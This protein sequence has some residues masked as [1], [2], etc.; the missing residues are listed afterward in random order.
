MNGPF[1]HAEAINQ[2]R[3]EVYKNGFFPVPVLGAYLGVK[4]AGKRPTMRNW[5]TVCA[6]AGPKKITDWTVA[7]NRDV[8][9]GLLCGKL[10]GLDVDVLDEQLV[11]TLVA[12]AEQMLGATPLRRTG[13]APKTLLCYSVIWPIK[14]LSTPELFFEDGTKAQ[15][16]ILGEGQQFVAFGIHG[17]THQPY[18]W[19]GGDPSNTTFDR[20]PTVDAADLQAYLTEAEE[21]LREAGATTRTERMQGRADAKQSDRER[22]GR[23]AAGFRHDEKPDRELI[24]EALDH[25][26]GDLHYDDWVKV[27]FALYDGLGDSGRDLWELWSSKSS[28]NDAPFT[29][30]KWPSFAQNRKVKIG[31]LF[32]FAKQNGWRRRPHHRMFEEAPAQAHAG[33]DHSEGNHKP[34]IK[35][36]PGQLPQVVDGAEQALIKASLGIYQRG[37]FVVRPTFT[38]IPISGGRKTIGTRIVPVKGAHVAEMM[39][40]AATFLEYSMRMEDWVPINCPERVAETYMAREGLWKVP[41]LAGVINCPTLRPD[42]S[43]LDRPGYDELTGLL[44]QP[45]DGDEF[46]PVLDQPSKEQA[47]EA[48]KF[49]LDL[50]ETFPFVTEA[51][52]SVAISAVLT[53]VIRRSLLTAPCHGFSAPTAGSGKSKLIDICSEICDGRG[54]AVVAAGKNPEETEKRLG[55]ALIAGDSIIS[56]DNVEGV[57]GGE[58]ICQALTQQVLKIRVLGHSSLAECP[59]NCSIFANGQ[60]L[61]LHGD[62]TRRAITCNIDPKVERPELRVF[63]RDPV[64]IVRADRDGYVNAALTV[65][66]AFHV[67]GRPNQVPPLGSFEDWSDW[68]RGSLIWLGMADP[69]LTMERA[70][71]QD[72]R[73]AQI[74]A[75]MAQWRVVIGS[76]RVSVKNVIDRAN[77]QTQATPD[78]HGQWSREYLHPEFREALLAVAGQ[79]TNVSSA[80]FGSWLGH[81]KGRLVGDMRIL[82]DTV[83]HGVGHWRLV[84]EDGSQGFGGKPSSGKAPLF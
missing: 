11:Q 61:V 39:T 28:K 5:D 22:Q 31:S 76:E 49:L 62:V 34:S 25:I 17:E 73:L 71:G 45:S 15:V 38:R 6:T 47:K 66:R 50:V 9:T 29:S 51:D 68:V 32:Y 41:T 80:R 53:S 44:Y 83:T 48:L 72:P 54:A 2:L 7:Y 60:N 37:S 18:S 64:A 20:I 82:A 40:R 12:R 79:G 8:N 36:I 14:K 69:C 43:V 19:H 74:M 75:V 63:D 3:L 57:F 27:G 26:P 30:R 58:L 52:R 81:N 70:R 35:N 13:R 65:L 56:I 77:A 1:S 78:A 59:T 55:S 23:K 46:S 24:A 33:Q 10:V 67:A 84:T 42:G 21:I 4:S 16:E